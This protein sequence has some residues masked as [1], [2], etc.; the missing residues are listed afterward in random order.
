MLSPTKRL[1]F[2]CALLV[3][4]I[5]GCANAP[6]AGTDD[7]ATFIIV[8]HAEKADDGSKDPPLSATGQARAD[9]LATWLRD[10]P[11]KAAY[12]TL[13]RRTQATATPAARAHSLAVTTYDT[14]MPATEFASQLRRDHHAGTVLVVGHSNTVADIAAALCGCT[15]ASTRDDQFDRR[16]TVRIDAEGHASLQE[17]RY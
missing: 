11:L 15:V 3:A 6:V 17:D 10:A 5:G 8:R 1:T 9:A 4:S 7:S 2:L 14:R 12:A 13:Y 16:L